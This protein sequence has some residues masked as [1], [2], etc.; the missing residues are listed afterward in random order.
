MKSPLNSLDRLFQAAKAA[1]LDPIPP[2]P[3][4]LPARVLAHGRGRG[5]AD[6]SFAG[7][8]PLFRRAFALGATI[9]V[10]SIAW[11]YAEI[12]ADTDD[13][14]IANFEVRADVLP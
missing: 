12:A 6:D 10:V 13:E 8:I 5:W 3:A 9:M 2:L 4:Y 14:A 7:L 1:P 11:S